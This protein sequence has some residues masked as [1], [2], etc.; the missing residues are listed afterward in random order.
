LLGR[1]TPASESR[2]LVR[3]LSACIRPA[4]AEERRWGAQRKREP[5]ATRQTRTV[6]NVSE[7]CYKSAIPR[8]M[9]G[10]ARLHGRERNN[11]LKYISPRLGKAKTACAGY[12]RQTV[13]RADPSYP[14][15]SVFYSRQPGATA[16][17]IA[18][19]LPTP[20]FC[21][22]NA[23][24]WIIGSPVAIK[25]PLMGNGKVHMGWRLMGCSLAGRKADMT[26][27]PRPCRLFLAA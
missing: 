11:Y 17:S 9:Q 2:R 12:S 1:V 3:H 15:Q 13:I 27:V 20:P 22:A 18:V 21:M 24:T 26:G 6:V 25:R 10:E 19:V 16:P 7:N 5:C 8:Y 4:H 14:C 23:R